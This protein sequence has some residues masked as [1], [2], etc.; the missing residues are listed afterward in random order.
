MNFFELNKMFG[1]L[2]MALIF[3][4]VTGMV[5]NFIFDD[6]PPKTPGFE[7]AVNDGSGG[8]APKKEEE[9]EEVDFATLL[10]SADVAKG[11]KF[12]KK[13]TSCHTFEAGGKN[14]IG[15]NLHGVFGRVIAGVDGFKYSAAMQEFGNGENW[16]VEK[17]QSFL[18]KP[19]S[20]GKTTMSYA[21]VKKP[22][23]LANLIGY[24]QSLSQ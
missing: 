19:K 20:I 4:M 17:L 14:K 5:T 18:A 8:A 24:L 15:P 16:T 3:A 22:K 21:G 13:C 6:N 9:E 1:V 7:I 10:A 23:D 11:E 12:T 2:L